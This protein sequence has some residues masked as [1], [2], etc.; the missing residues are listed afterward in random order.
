[1]LSGFAGMVISLRENGYLA[2]QE[3]LSRYARMVIRLWRNGYLATQ[4]LLIGNFR[5]SENF[6]STSHLSL[7]SLCDEFLESVCHKL[8]AAM[9]DPEDLDAVELVYKC[10]SVLIAH[11]EES[12]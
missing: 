12:G 3:W 5:F 1:M 6:P 8:F 10:A 7:I 4:E 11:T 9:G 2:S